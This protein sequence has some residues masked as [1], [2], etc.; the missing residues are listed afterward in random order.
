MINRRRLTEALTSHRPIRSLGVD[1]APLQPP[2]EPLTGSSHAHIIGP[3]RA[4][5][6]LLGYVVALRRFPVKPEAG[7]TPTA[8]GS[9]STEQPVNA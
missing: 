8:S 3:L 4:F 5:A 1:L 9:S 6:G 2:C 7:A